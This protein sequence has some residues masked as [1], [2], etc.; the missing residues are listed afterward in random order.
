MCMY[1]F[2]FCS[3]LQIILSME[4]NLYERQIYLNTWNCVDKIQIP[5]SALNSLV[6]DLQEQKSIH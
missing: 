1:S 6:R 2:L 3:N 5:S 4:N